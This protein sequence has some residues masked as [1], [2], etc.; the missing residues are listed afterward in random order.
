[1]NAMR[2]K[3]IAKAIGCISEAR[4]LLEEVQSDEQ[5]AYDSLPLSIQD[6][7]RGERMAEIVSDLENAV[8]ELE[9]LESVLE[10][11]RA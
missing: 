11:A 10:D 6:S 9:N 5:T 2:R 7:G 3:M 1:M 4:S 8:S